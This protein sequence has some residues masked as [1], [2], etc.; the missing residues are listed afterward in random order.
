M[1]YGLPKNFNLGYACINTQL[2]KNDIFTSRTLRLDTYKKLGLKYVKEL[3]IQ[4]LKDLLTILKWNVENKIFFFRLSS[5]MFPFASHPE[6]GY[7]LEFA[8]KLLKE[9]GKYA[10]KNNI[11][12]TMHP[13]PYN[14]LTSPNP[15]IIRNTIL[16]LTH[17]CE[18]L[19]RMKLD[20]NSVMILHGGGVY[21]NK[22]LALQTLEINLKKLPKYILNRIILENDEISYSIVDLLPISEKLKI[23]I[24]VDFH[25]DS[26]NPSPKPPQFY[27]NKIF[28]IWNKR[29]IKP[30]IHISNSSPAI[31]KSHNI[32]E[33]RK[34][35]DIIVFIH[36]AIQKIKF[37]LDV[38][39]ECKLKEQCVFAIRN[40]PR[41]ELF[42]SY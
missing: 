7:K 30:K 9:V 21:G 29:K 5:E 11:R 27:F 23:P 41:S 2:R 25:H 38:M 24:V 3:A 20:K 4:N 35:S 16:D 17:H 18:I 31:T 6:Y 32:M 42:Q 39:L 28:D 34:H 19:D 12:L 40:T 10:K 22:E 33:K 15:N 37:D 8:D 13:G 26:L 36:A 14:N 1:L